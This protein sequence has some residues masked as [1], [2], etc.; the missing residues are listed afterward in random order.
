MDEA[1]RQQRV[2]LFKQLCRE[3]GERC[4]VQRQI[5]L[6]TVLAAPHL[7]SRGLIQTHQPGFHPQTT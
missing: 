6:E 7:K 5:I 4:T 2:E 1:T 3:K